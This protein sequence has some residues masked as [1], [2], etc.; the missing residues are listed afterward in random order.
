MSKLSLHRIVTASFG[1]FFVAVAL[2]I[3]AA[4]WAATPIEAAIAALIIGGLGADAIIG[5]VRDR[6]SLLSRIGPLP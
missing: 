1:A 6:R 5:A 3:L 4:A 2:L